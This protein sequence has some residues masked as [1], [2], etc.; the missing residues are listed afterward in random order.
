MPKP[1]GVFVNDTDGGESS[2]QSNPAGVNATPKPDDGPASVIDGFERAI[3]PDTVR[4]NA[5]GGAET[6]RRTKTGKIDGRT[7][8]GRNTG[9]GTYA[10]TPSVSQDLNKISLTELLFSLHQMGAAFLSVAELELDK[11]EAEKLG[12]AIKDVGKFYAMQF[13]PKKVAIANL[14]VI[15]GGIYGTR[16]VAYRTRRKME[17]SKERIVEMPN[18]NQD[19]EQPRATKP[20]GQAAPERRQTGQPMRAPSDLWPESGTIHGDIF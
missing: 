5:A 1:I 14:M 3:D 10:E 18:R 2:P 13:D 19:P 7:R 20:N 8:A 11:S 4:I 15:A 16:Y 17:R 6:V 9:T 12:N